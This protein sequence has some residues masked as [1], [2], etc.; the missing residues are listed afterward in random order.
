MKGFSLDEFISKIPVLR[1]FAKNLALNA[2]IAFVIQDFL[3][4]LYSTFIF[5]IVIALFV[6]AIISLVYWYSIY[7]KKKK[8]L[9]PLFSTS[10]FSM[11]YSFN[12]GR[13]SQFCF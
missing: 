8:K 2:G 9:C 5:D 7:K 11:Y 13:S 10:F 1:L 4:P 6:F 3:I 12:Y